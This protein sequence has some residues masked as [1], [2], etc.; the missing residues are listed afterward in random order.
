MGMRKAEEGGDICIHMADSHCCK[1]ET[2]TMY[3]AIMFQ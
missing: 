2:N 3:K 1:A